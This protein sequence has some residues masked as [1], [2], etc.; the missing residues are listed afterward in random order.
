M[1]S[2]V[3]I[4][5]IAALAG[6]Q[7]AS[8]QFLL[9]AESTGDRVLLLNSQDGSV[10]DGNF[11]DI[12]AAAASVN[13]TGGIT[14]IEAMQVGSEF[15][16]TDQVADRIW[17]FDLNGGFLGNYGVDAASGDGQLNNI[18]GF[19]VV[20]GVAYIAQASDSD[21]PGGQSEG[22]ITMDVATGAITGSFIGV[23]AGDAS[24]WDVK[25]IGGQLYVTNSDTGNDGIYIYDTDGTYNGAFVTSD[26]VTGVD[27]PQ[28]INL[29]A[30]GNLIV[31]GFSQPSG[32]YEFM[33]DGT[34][35]GIVA[36]TANLGPRAAFELGNGEILFS[37]GIV[38]NR[39]GPDGVV[40]EG[41]ASFRFINAT[42]VPAPGAIAALGLAGLAGM[43]RRRA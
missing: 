19:E 29:R 36:G 13:Y 15:W 37:H 41:G 20:D 3:L 22:I 12:G 21:V 4:A 5:A 1:K 30:N 11:L 24:Y 8:A 35:V 10:V 42:S 23:D 31:G 14:P 43:R 38:L 6:A 7:A 40:L 18:R 26:G 27:Q 34:D 25:N 17:R 28:Q 39:T 2:S 32:V 33:N 9:V 16:V